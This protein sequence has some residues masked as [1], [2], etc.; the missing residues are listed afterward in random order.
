M[1]LYLERREL[2]VARGV[3]RAVLR[4]VPRDELGVRR[5]A[6]L[7]GDHLPNMDDHTSET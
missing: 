2:R 1:S 5:R 7:G 6:Q 4:V 3:V